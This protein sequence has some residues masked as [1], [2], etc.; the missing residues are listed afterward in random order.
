MA[1]SD[2]T[3]GFQADEFRT[4][5]RNAM[6]LGLPEDEAER[7]IFLFPRER[8]YDVRDDGGQPFDW[9]ETPATDTD[10]EPGEP[11]QVTC[12]T[13]ADQV[14]CAYE[15]GG[16][17]GGTQPTETVVG[18]FDTLRMVITMLDV[19][20]RKVV[21]FDRVIIG[22]STYQYSVEEASVGLYDVTVYQL[23]VTAED[24]GAPVR[25]S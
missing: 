14:V 4:N 22:R 20:R 5:I 18:N 12:G 8:T 2:P 15:A 3:G 25:T 19:D 9:S 24:L 7:P 23:V 13:G 17:R 21:G 11:R 1:G 6:L 10:T 16:G